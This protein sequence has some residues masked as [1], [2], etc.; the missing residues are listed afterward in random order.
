MMVI[1]EALKINVKSS[2]CYKVFLFGLHYWTLLT[3][4]THYSLRCWYIPL[5]PP[6]FPVIYQWWS[7]L[8]SLNFPSASRVLGSGTNQKLTLIQWFSHVEL[9]W[10]N[11][12]YYLIK[13]SIFYGRFFSCHL[14]QLYSTDIQSWTGLLESVIHIYKESFEWVVYCM[15]SFFSTELYKDFCLMLCSY[16]RKVIRSAAFFMYFMTAVLIYF[17]MVSCFIYIVC[18]HKTTETFS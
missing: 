13:E 6:P 16:Y 17:I 10:I 2:L 7:S 12:L 11:P 4:V 15:K 5:S 3:H 14:Y 18:R 9:S 1:G 8:L